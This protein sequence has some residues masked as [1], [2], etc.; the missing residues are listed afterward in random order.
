VPSIAIPAGGFVARGA[1][2]P[3]V[4]EPTSAGA[5]LTPHKL[6][7][8][9][10]LTGEMARN[11]N[12]E[13]LIRQALIESA[14]PTIDK[15]YSRPLRPQPAPAGLLNGIAALTPAAPG[16]KKRDHYR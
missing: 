14:G 2:I 11:V 12:A 10:W 13:Q 5:T 3:V 6:A 15:S 9:T 8:M 4:I 7:V 1:P 16:D